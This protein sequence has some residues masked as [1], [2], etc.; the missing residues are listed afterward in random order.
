MKLTSPNS[1]I[2]VTEIR[3]APQADTKLSKKIGSVCKTI[4]LSSQ[5]IFFSLKVYKFNAIIVYEIYLHCSSI[6][7]QQGTEQKMLPFHNWQYF[8]CCKGEV[9]ISNEKRKKLE[10]NQSLYS[11]VKK[12]ITCIFSIIWCSRFC[13]D[14]K[15]N[16]PHR[17]ES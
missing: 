12:K 8:C 7:E 13:K 6:A 10:A 3:I 15:I 5:I 11:H 9:G 1:R 16:K 17:H 2:K 4:E 14:L